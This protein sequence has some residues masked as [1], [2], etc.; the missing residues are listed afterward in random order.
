VGT[1]L[2]SHRP[3][4][5]ARF[6]P[7]SVHPAFPVSKQAEHGYLRLGKKRGQRLEWHQVPCMGDWGPS[8]QCT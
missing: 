4:R 1:P 5:V 2:P 6:I 8:K 3:I 7:I